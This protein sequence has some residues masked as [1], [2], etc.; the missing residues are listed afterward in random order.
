[1]R[2]CIYSG[3]K[4]DAMVKLKK[5][6]K[7]EMWIIETTDSE[8]YHNCVFLS[9]YDLTELRRLLDYNKIPYF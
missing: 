7:S 8:G 3:I 6:K 4:N 9:L 1:M 2:L 5:D